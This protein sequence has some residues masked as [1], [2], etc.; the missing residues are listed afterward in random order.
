MTDCLRHRD[1]ETMDEA[2]KEVSNEKMAELMQSIDQ[3][4]A[5]LVSTLG[6]SNDKS[7]TNIR[8][9]VK[10]NKNCAAAG[11]DSNDMAV[12]GKKR[13]SIEEDASS[14]IAM[15]DHQP[16]SLNPI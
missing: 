10:T 6:F 11:A 2:K 15:V 3:L 8:E 13:K 14:S 9:F 1:T 5:L 16:A 4:D 7:I 12:A